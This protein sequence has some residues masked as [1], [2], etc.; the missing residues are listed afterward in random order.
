M[1]VEQSK[2]PALMLGDPIFEMFPITNKDAAHVI[3]EQMDDYRG[4]MNARGVN[5]PATGITMVGSFAFQMDPGRYGEYVLLTEKEIE[6][7]R[8][9]GSYEGTLDISQLV[10][11]AQDRLLDRRL[12]RIKW[13]LWTLL[14]TG[15][16]SVPGPNGGIIHKDQFAFQTASASV[17]WATT[18]TAVPLQDLRAA[19]LKARGK[20]VRF[21][22]TSRMFMNQ[23]TMN[24]LLNNTNPSDLFAKRLENGSTINSKADLDA[25]I[26]ANDLPQAVVWD[27]GY[28]T[29]ANVFTLYIPN[30][31]VIII[32]S[33]M[34][35]AAVG[36]F[37]MTRN[38]MNDSM[39]PGPYTIVSDSAN[40]TG[41]A[42]IPRVVRVDD[43]FNGG[44][45]V[46]FPGAVIILSC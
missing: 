32:G 23:Q 24:N 43:G 38:V 12:T 37:Q 14:A 10:F 22:A 35:G 19:K 4:L 39:A 6:N 18:A 44:P 27:D 9:L 30:N 7:R 17:A 41:Q 15:I 36:E 34:S 26:L 42:V 31:T 1:E 40:A 8:P 20:S 33:R 21:D 29:D 46:F 25:V 5:D 2:L 11:R 3:W 16:F 13:I 45:A 28:F